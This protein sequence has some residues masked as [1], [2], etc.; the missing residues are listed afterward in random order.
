[1]AQEFI[2]TTVN[3]LTG[4]IDSSSFG[5]SS[6]R[7]NVFAC[8]TRNEIIDVIC[9]VGS[10]ASIEERTL[11]AEKVWLKRTSD[12]IMDKFNLKINPERAFRRREITTEMN[13]QLAIMSRDELE[14]FAKWK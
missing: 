7:R 1:M 6:P 11:I 12:A 10:T 2:A 14:D 4:Q 3:G 9:S 5:D 13:A 8:L